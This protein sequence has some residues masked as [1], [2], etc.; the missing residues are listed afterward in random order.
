M[1]AVLL[2]SFFVGINKREPVVFIFPSSSSSLSH[3]LSPFSS[4]R[5]KLCPD[6]SDHLQIFLQTSGAAGPAH[7]EVSAPPTPPLDKSE[8][9]SLSPDALTPPTLLPLQGSRSPSRGPARWTRWTEGSSPSA[10][11][12]S[13]SARS[14]CSRCSSGSRVTPSHSSALSPSSAA[15]LWTSGAPPRRL[16]RALREPQ[17]DVTA[18]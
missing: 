4:L 11:S 18:R 16:L 15:C 10:P 13:A 17:C 9:P 5:S 14:L 8:T 3:S 12:S 1:S 6:I 7:R 2:R